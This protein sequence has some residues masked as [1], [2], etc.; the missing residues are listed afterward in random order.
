MPE[1]TQMTATEAPITPQLPPNTNNEIETLPKA[2]KQDVEYQTLPMK[3][4]E[5]KEEEKD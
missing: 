1:Q 2:V 4:E 3:T 5:K